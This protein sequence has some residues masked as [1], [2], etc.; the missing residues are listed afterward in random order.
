MSF[1]RMALFL[2]DCA[3]RWRI[4]R[5]SD[6][7]LNSLS[8]S[9]NHKIS[10]FTLSILYNWWYGKNV[11]NYFYFSLFAPICSFS[12]LIFLHFAWAAF[13]NAHFR[14]ATYECLRKVMCSFVYIK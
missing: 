12:P 11:L 2:N 4:F 13:P 7:S 10:F 6:C 1:S 14:Q 8:V 5:E 9:I 3:L